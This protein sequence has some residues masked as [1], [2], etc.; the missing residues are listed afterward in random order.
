MFTTILLKLWK[1]KYNV[2]KDIFTILYRCGRHDGYSSCGGND[3]DIDTMEIV[4]QH[5]MAGKVLV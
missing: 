5:N 4:N 3:N 2:E 1:D